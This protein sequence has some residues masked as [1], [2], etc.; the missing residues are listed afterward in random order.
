MQMRRVRTDEKEIR[1]Y[2][3]ECWFPYQEEV[4]E[5]V[6]AYSLDDDIDTAAIVEHHLDEL[7]SPS[8]RLWV[9]LDDVEGSAVALSETDATF[10]GFI[11]TSVPSIPDRFTWS[12]RLRIRDLWVRESDRGS[13]LADD[14]IQRAIQQAREAGCEELTLR[15]GTEN[16]Q[17]VS[18]FETLGFEE[19]GLGMNVPLTDVALKRDDRGEARSDVQFRRLRIKDSAIDR[20]VE[21]CWLP[22]WED[23]GEATGRAYLDSDLDRAALVEDLSEG[24]D[25]PDRRCWIVLDDP[26]DETAPL[27]EMDAEFAGWI[28][29]GPEPTEEYLDP[30]ERLFIGNL[31]VAPGYRG[32]GLVDELI[33]R[34]MQY[35]REEGCVEFS[36]GVEAT[37]ERAKAYY[38]KLGFESYRQKMSV[39][40]DSIELSCSTTGYGDSSVD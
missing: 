4:S 15:V 26:E 3:E 13:G 35:A 40:L 25:V 1:R 19:E 23:M 17:A 10:A 38:K 2:V 9:A 33:E 11:R 20:F 12:E 30:A 36:L 34:A 27:E 21:E 18:Y 37:N 6:G 16:E 22:F 39:S 32:T 31:Y 29:A 28:N 8:D 14:L 7:D 24:Y 5:R